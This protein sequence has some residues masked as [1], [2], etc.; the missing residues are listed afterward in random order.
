[1]TGRLIAFCGPAG[2]G[3]STAAE[4]LME[5]G[6]VRVKFADPLKNMLRSFYRSCGIDD[7]R[8]I[9]ARIEGGMKEEPDPYLRG[10]TPRHAMQTLG[11][12]WGRQ[13]IAEDLW[14]DTW[15]Q[16]AMSVLKR[17]M[18]VVCDDCR[19]PNEAATVRKLRGRVVQI[20]GREK[21]VTKSHSSEKLDF[22]PDMKIHNIANLSG[23]T[24]DVIHIF[25]RTYAGE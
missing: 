19:F 10:R 14:I 13:S 17:D 4:A 2:C 18:D 11:T 21:G 15:A 9:E 8:Y 1:M 3:K 23:F 12:E 25:D 22:E 5:E 20:I 24:N 6:W 7:E 16:R